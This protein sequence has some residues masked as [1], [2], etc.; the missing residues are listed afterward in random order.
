[1]PLQEHRHFI[2]RDTYRL[3]VF[4]QRLHPAMKLI[5]RF[6]SLRNIIYT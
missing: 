3:H 1:M 5:D 2:L 4:F 6:M